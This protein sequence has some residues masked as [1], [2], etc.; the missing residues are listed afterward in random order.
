MSNTLTHLVCSCSIRYFKEMLETF[1]LFLF[2]KKF[3]L[4]TCA[5]FQSM[6]FFIGKKKGKSRYDTT[7]KIRYC[8]KLVAII[9]IAHMVYSYRF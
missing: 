6:N 7:F 4:A 9:E 3:Y 1:S 2:I 5:F 8:F